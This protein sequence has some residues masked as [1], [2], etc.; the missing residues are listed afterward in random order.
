MEA[1]GE[2]KPP[3]GSK[4]RVILH[5]GWRSVIRDAAAEMV[6]MVHPDIGVEP[7]QYRS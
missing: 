6:D 4:L 5:H 3:D 2:R 7:A 1:L